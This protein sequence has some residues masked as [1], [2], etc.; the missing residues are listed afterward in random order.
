MPFVVV[1]ASVIVAAVAIDIAQLSPCV[2]PKHRTRRPQCLSGFSFSCDKRICS[3][4]QNPLHA[5]NH[6]ML[7]N[8]F[9]PLLWWLK[10]KTP[11]KAKQA[12]SHPSSYSLFLVHAPRPNMVA[13]PVRTHGCRIGDDAIT[14]RF[15]C[16]L[17]CCRRRAASIEAEMHFSGAYETG[18]S[19]Q[20][21]EPADTSE[22]I[23]ADTPDD[24]DW[25]SHLG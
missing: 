24:N 14:R 13:E 21:G 5:V 15:S 11:A 12:I 20:D 10:S 1:I 4:Q 25:H 9:P 16:R 2:E 23:D 17:L 22:V 7:A 6:V 3:H 8:L 18:N 19:C